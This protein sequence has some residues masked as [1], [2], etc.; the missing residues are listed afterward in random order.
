MQDIGLLGSEGGGPGTWSSRWPAATTWSFRGPKTCAASIPATTE[1]GPGRCRRPGLTPVH[2]T[3]A[4]AELGHGGAGPAGIIPGE[5]FALDL[6]RHLVRRACRRPR[7][8][9]HH[10]HAEP[11][12]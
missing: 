2:V 1:P 10:R 8:D 9:D 6:G 3:L 5:D 12:N 11:S 4:S 7:Q